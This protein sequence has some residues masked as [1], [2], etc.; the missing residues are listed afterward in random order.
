MANFQDLKVQF[1]F[2]AGETLT[3]EQLDTKKISCVILPRCCLYDQQADPFWMNGVWPL[4]LH[5]LDTIVP[6]S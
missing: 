5:R 2:L 3:F 6:G 4:R 1:T